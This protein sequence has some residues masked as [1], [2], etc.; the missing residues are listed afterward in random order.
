MRDVKIETEINMTG[1]ESGGLEENSPV[2]II[3]NLR[4]K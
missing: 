3:Q 1:E 2:R 4:A